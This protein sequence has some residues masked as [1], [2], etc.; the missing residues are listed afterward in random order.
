M[1]IY[2]F[3]AI[4]L[5]CMA[6]TTKRK[7]TSSLIFVCI[8]LFIISGFRSLSV[9]TDTINYAARFDN[10]DISATT[11]LFEYGWYYLNYLFYYSR[12]SV[13][14]VFIV[15]AFA[16]IYL[17]Y[18][19]V[20]KESKWPLFSL[21]L[22]ILFFYYFNSFNII[23]QTIAE[24]IVF[25]AVPFL[26]NGKKKD[27]LIFYGLVLLAMLFH[28]SAVIAF[29]I[30]LIQYVNINKRSACFLLISSII[31]GNIPLESFILSQ[32]FYFLSDMYSHYLEDFNGVGV[33]INRLIMNAYIILYLYFEKEDLGFYSKIM[34]LGIVLQNAFPY[35]II[36]RMFNYLVIFS[37]IAVADLCYDKNKKLF[38]ISTMI[39]GTV[40][41]SLFLSTNTCGIVPYDFINLSDILKL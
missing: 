25:F 41:F 20:S 36:I 35:P 4:I 18:K 17:F 11:K 2:I 39:Y 21:L 37:I 30:P 12:F 3:I 31:I 23:R 14:A 28:T 15:S 7:S 16:T 6:I 38:T 26:I 29:A 22:Y 24:A 32:N 34:I 10:I 1:A 33:S 9:G 27:M 8:I 40:K 5:F 13:H 19:T